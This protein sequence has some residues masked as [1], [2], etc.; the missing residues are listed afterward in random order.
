M[1]ICLNDVRQRFYLDSVALMRYARQLIGL[2]GVSNAALMIGTPSNK[3]ILAD[4]ELLSKPG[5]SAGAND[6]IIAVRADDEDAAQA[7]LNKAQALLTQPAAQQKG[8][9]SRR[10]VRSLMG[11]LQQLPEANLALISVPGEFAA[12]EARK[13]LRRGLHVMLFSDNV[14]LSDERSLKLEAQERGLLL[15][16]PDC[17][18]AILG[19]APL[20]FANVVPRGDIGLISASGTG[21]QEVSCLIA[22]LGGGVSHAIGVGGRDLKDEIGAISTLMAFDALE[23]DASTRHIVL[24]SKPPGSKV[25][26]L[27]LERIAR[28]RKPVTLCFMGVSSLSLP[29]HAKL[30]ITLQDAAEKALGQNLPEPAITLPELGSG[31]RWLRGLYSGGTLCAEAQAILRELPGLQS[32]VPLSG[33]ATYEKKAEKPVHSLLDLGA[34]DY[35]V[36]RPHPMLDPAMRNQLLADTLRDN[37]VAVILLDVV[38]GYGAHADPAAALAKTITAAPTQRP[39]IIASVTGTEADPQGYSRQRA[40]LRKA[41]VLVAGSNAQATQW[42]GRLLGL[43]L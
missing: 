24:I 29:P 41:G 23:R 34:D 26:A 19:G 18:T 17:G 38:I 14:S 1:S 28:S 3:Q 21:L 33:I 25:T 8:R 36:G 43:K 20:A 15:M 9:Q 16:G 40:V 39:V 37:T 31:R 12:V 10:Q 27:I 32:N 22:R 11:A 42:A 35:T 2:P 13:A 7:A 30:A 6:L 4:A 5:Q